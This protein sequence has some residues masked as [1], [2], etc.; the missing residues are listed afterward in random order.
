MLPN[1]HQK[2]A[3]LCIDFK[4]SKMGN[5][6]KNPFTISFLA[7]AM[8]VQPSLQELDAFSEAV[9]MA[10]KAGVEQGAMHKSL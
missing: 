8:G 4:F 6:R 9:V 7:S 2:N 10:E 3:L 1:G 5:P